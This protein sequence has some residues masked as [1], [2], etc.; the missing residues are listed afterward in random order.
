V[1]GAI[2]IA[3]SMGISE[4][5]I[6][7]SVVAFGT[8]LPELATSVVAA[9]KD[10]SDISVGNIIG[11][12]LCNILWIIGLVGLIFELPVD[13]RSLTFDFPVM[14]GFSVL[15]YPILRTGFRVGRVKGAFLLLGYAAYVTSL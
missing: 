3:T 1:S 5:V 15:L 13:E 10:E 2:S 12:N 6:A 8:S 9:V 4:F 14:I 11:S 7:V